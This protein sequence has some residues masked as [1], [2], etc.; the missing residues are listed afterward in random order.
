[1]KWHIEIREK[2]FDAIGEGVLRDILDLGITTVKKVFF[3]QVYNIV[4][5][6]SFLEVKKIC[7]E[8]LVDR[9]TQ[10]YTINKPHLAKSRYE[11]VVE[12]AYNPGVMDPVEG[13]VVKAIR[14]LGIKSP[15]TVKTAK[16]YILEGRLNNFQLNTICEKLLYNKLIQHIVKSSE[17][18]VEELRLPEYQFRL[19]TIPILEANDKK[20]MAISRKGQLFLNLKEMQTIKAYFKKLG[21]NPTDCELETIAQ[22]WSE[23]CIHKTFKGKIR[24][25]EKIKN[26]KSRIKIINNLLK[27]TIMKSTE[28]LKKPWCI[29]VFK[30]NSGVIRFD[31]R[32]N[33]CFKV[34][35]HN[36]PSALEPYGGANT[37]I[38]GVIRDPLGTGLG[39]KPIFNTDVFCFAP[40]DYPFKK[41]PPG[42][43]HP[44]RI[45]KG[46]VAGVRD[47]GNKMGIPTINGAILFHEGFIGNP[48]VYCGTAGILPKEKSFKEPK[49]TDLIVLVGGRTGRDGIHGATFSSGE[50]TTES[51]KVSS[52]AVQIGN[53]IEEK[54]MQE[55]ILEA[56][57]KN[58][59]NAITDCGGGGLSSAVG[60]M[61]K[62]LG[63]EVYLEKVP[64]K[65][66]GLSYT[67]IWISESQERMILSVPK[68]KLNKLLEIFK[69]EDVEATVIGKFTDTKK[70]KLYYK[71]NLVCNL[72]MK[73]LHQGLPKIE[74]KAIFVKRNYKEPNFKEP[75]D[76]K[77][78]LLRLLS[79]PDIASK[80]WVIRQYDHEVQGGSILKPLVGVYNDGPSDASIVRPILNSKRGL[81]V[82]S[83]I[84]F[85]F[86]FIDPYWMA[87]SCIDEA[88]RQIIAVGGSLE[89]VALLDNFC[90]GNP[91]K[92]DRLGSLVRTA[93]GCYDFALGFGVP[94]ISGKDSLNNEYRI[95]NK[96]ISIPGTLLISAIAVME[97]IHKA[98]SMYLKKPKDLI[99]IVGQTYDEL[100]GSH[101]YDLFGY[102]GNN[103]PKVNTKKA[104]QVFEALSKA[105]SEG[106]IK[107]M[108][109]CSEGGLA[110]ALA[111]MAFSGDLGVEVFLNEVPYKGNQIRNDF[112]LFSESNSRFIVEIEKEDQ[113]KF[114]NILEGVPF[115]LIG[116]VS[117][118]KIFNVYGLDGKLCISAGILDL[119]E[120]WQKPLRW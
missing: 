26:Q 111:E 44:K 11:S 114:E 113:K 19:I 28:K 25:I 52:G 100:G 82:S 73:F 76:L 65:Y 119:K 117:K 60:E 58:L 107:A 120:A 101:Y 41:L 95:K 10:N 56:R 112:V 89:E 62:D 96:S 78:Y 69:K 32:Y 51:E 31:K 8:L 7:E 33:V 20:L 63:V 27:S 34:E 59:Y 80:E 57:D 110:V 75:K 39:A 45:M 50:L 17:F 99:Y 43:L 12:I 14:D 38:G 4:G 104:K 47:Y 109:D 37:G 103:V 6:I 87:G 1:M 48:L 90:W 64:L 61:G 35:T 93:L 88:L 24:Y 97:D 91:D 9:I 13:S 71:N 29:S 118:D 77:K 86:G 42:V 18:E 3:I 74:K 54:K 81:I 55:A 116:C 68:N 83:G 84:N 98:I 67:E 115:G 70:L 105:N 53:P 15:I 49:S 79:H 46:V 2:I 21:R 102:I 22:T 5:E 108:H 23:H 94:F 66:Q 40:P 30:D 36:H 72:D 92:P 106:I 85:R 16:K